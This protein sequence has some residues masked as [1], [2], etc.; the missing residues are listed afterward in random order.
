MKKYIIGVAVIVENKEGNILIGYDGHKKKWALPGGHWEG[1]TNGETYEEGALREV[2]EETGGKNGKGITCEIKCLAY[3]V[4]FY[5]KD[6][7][8]WYKSYGYVAN[9]LNGELGN[10][11]EEDRTR[12]QFLP[13]EE[14]LKLDLFEPAKKGLRL[15]LR[16][17]VKRSK[18]FPTIL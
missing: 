8:K 14:V 12:W 11:L 10:D 6:K 5:R 13:I 3:E 2:F 7:E 17:K 9:Y 15:Y 4:E 18:E 1:E 16:D